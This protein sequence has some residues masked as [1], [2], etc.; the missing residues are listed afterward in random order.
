MTLWLLLIT[1]PLVI[2]DLVLPRATRRAWEARLAVHADT[3]PAFHAVLPSA[4]AR[5]RRCLAGGEDRSLFAV[6]PLASG[7]LAASAAGALVLGLGSAALG[8]AGVFTHG[9][10]HFAIPGLAVGLL[11]LVGTYAVIIGAAP[12]R[13]LLASL[14]L[15]LVAVGLG[16]LA[17]LTLMHAATWLEWQ[18]KRTAVAW[19]SEWFYAEAYLAYLREPAG[20]VISIA[21]AVVVGGVAV[22]WLGEV[23]FGLVAALA[24]RL[25]RAAL[26]ISA[27]VP[28]G[29]IAAGVGILLWM[30][31]KRAG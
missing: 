15:L 16:I 23:A 31:L 30:V 17:W 1:V 5:A 2:L 3:A 13:S 22:W 24:P 18:T 26:A 14:G 12:P 9:V 25:G 4:S 27:R 21:A 10:R 8:D 19:G 28:R 11:S 20:R 29:A 7:L 6:R